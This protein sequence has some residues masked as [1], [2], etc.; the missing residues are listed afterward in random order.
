MLLLALLIAGAASVNLRDATGKCAQ[1]CPDWRSTW[2]SALCFA[3]CLRD[4]VPKW[5]QKQMVDNDVVDNKVTAMNLN[6][7]NQYK[8]KN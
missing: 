1:A 4:D 5:L 6:R 7:R 2:L 8:P 3:A